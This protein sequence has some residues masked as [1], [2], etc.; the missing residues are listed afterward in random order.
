MQPATTLLP[1]QLVPI[2]LG[3]VR[4]VSGDAFEDGDDLEGVELID[5]R[6]ADLT[7][8]G[9]R[10]L[11][12]SHIEGLSV[13]SWRARGALFIDS[14]LERVEVLALTAPESGWRDV[15]VSGSRLGAVEA[16]DAN[17]RRVRFTGCKLGYLNLRDA[18]LLDVQFTDC[19]IEELDLMRAKA[20]RIGFS[21][22]R[23]GRLDVNNAKLEHT[24]LRGAQLADISGVEGLRGATLSVDQLLDLA[25]MLA[26]RLGINVD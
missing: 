17:L 9:R 14:I 23:I 5:V 22:C 16:Y 7:W 12:S 25:P 3:E 26:A 8:T 18:T 15:A 10:R 11:D 13:D 21:N 19:I 24:D 2:E 20:R 1:P 6:L 4:P